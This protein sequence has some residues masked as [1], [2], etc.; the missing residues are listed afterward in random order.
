MVRRDVQVLIAWCVLFLSTVA[1]AQF[2]PTGAP[3]GEGVLPAMRVSSVG[4]DATVTRADGSSESV[5]EG[6]ELAEGD[7]I[8]TG[9]SSVVLV[10]LVDLVDELV[11]DEIAIGRGT[12]VRFGRTAAPR[13]DERDYRVSR[14]LALEVAGVI[15]LTTTGLNADSPVTIP[16][17]ERRVVMT[18]ADVTVSIPPRDSENAD[19]SAPT[20][21]LGD[22][23]VNRGMAYVV[24]GRRRLAT[25]NGTRRVVTRGRVNAAKSFEPLIWAQAIQ[26]MQIGGVVLAAEQ[27]WTSLDAALNPD[28]TGYVRFD[29]SLGPF[30]IEVRGDV[31]PKTAANFMKYVGEDFYPKTIFH[32]VFLEPN[33]V[34]QGGGLDAE[35]EV[36][37][38]G[39]PI[40]NEWPNG[41]RNVRGTVA[42]AR[43]RA[44]M[45]TTSQFFVNTKHN[46][47]YDQKR[48]AN[49][50]RGYCVF[51]R[52]VAGMDVVDAIN[53]VPTE[54]SEGGVAGAP[55]E[56]I[57]I[58]VARE[59]DRGVLA[60]LPVRDPQAGPLGDPAGGREPRKQP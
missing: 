3:I 32:R 20:D 38:P 41:L 52:V 22:V 6:M 53:A 51:G 21:V 45:S 56:P 8:A 48:L 11:L 1:A 33:A 4:G 17:G 16:I 13:E 28:A 46:E 40:A 15:R 19:E 57:R 27:P 42:A 36:V 44:P 14:P 25:R 18:G 55:I 58:F 30:V 59:I 2:S 12:T 26:P 35:M 31:S 37:Q 47:K 39:L 34:V 49:G 29:T 10:E 54:T 7:S 60:E 9:A 43:S 50:R 5:A 24:E 23:I